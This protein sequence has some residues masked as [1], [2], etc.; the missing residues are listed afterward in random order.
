VL[1]KSASVEAV[2]VGEAYTYT[3]NVANFEATQATVNLTDTLPS[4]TTYVNGSATGGLVYNAGPETLT[5]S[6]VLDPVEL[7][8]EP[9]LSVDA[10]TYMALPVT[11]T[12]SICQTFFASCDEA[13]FTVGFAPGDYFEYLGVQYTNLSLSSNGFVVYGDSIPGSDHFINQDLPD[14]TVPNNLVAGFWTDLDLDGASASDSGGGDWLINDVNVG[15]TDYFVAEY[16]NA[17]L[18]GNPTAFYTFQLWFE[19]NSNNVW[20]VYDDLTGDTSVGTVGAEN[21]TGEVGDNYYFDGAGTLPAAG[22]SLIVRNTLDTHT[23][24][25]AVTVDAG[26]QPGTLI[27]NR[28]EATSSALPGVV[29]AA[30]EDVRLAFPEIFLPIIAR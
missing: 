1:N 29:F 17:Q 22:D 23:F 27:K 26:T 2:E 6:V 7:V 18:F 13:V 12:L 25:Y 19:Y 10:P 20:L 11:G 15:G 5:G 24:T 9:D 28:V 21:A 8:V 4:E 30:V 14:P 3:I 16:R